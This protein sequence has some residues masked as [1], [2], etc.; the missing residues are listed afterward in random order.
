[1]IRLL[2]IALMILLFVSCTQKLYKD[3]QQFNNKIEKDSV[4]EITTLEA[5]PIYIP[6][7]SASTETKLTAS[8]DTNGSLIFEEKT[9]INNSGRAQSHTTIDRHGNLKTKCKCKAIEDSLMVQKKETIRYK[10][11]YETEKQ[12]NNQTK[13]VYKTP[14][15]AY[16]M[17]L[18]ALVTTLIAIF[19]A[20]HKFIKPLKFLSFL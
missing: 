20:V 11:L 6:G 12:S 9:I 4:S 7:D 13:V 2:Y 15:W 1:M 3:N 16:V 17:I 5:L 19:L 8:I 18:V 10:F 14:L